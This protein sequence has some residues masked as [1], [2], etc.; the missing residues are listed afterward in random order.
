MNRIP[1]T[2]RFLIKAQRPNINN[3]CLMRSDETKSFRIESGRL[4]NIAV[5]Y[6][7]ITYWDATYA[8]YIRKG[9]VDIS[10]LYFSGNGLPSVYGTNELTAA[11][12]LLIRLLKAEDTHLEIPYITDAM[13]DKAYDI[14]TGMK[15]MPRPQGGNKADFNDLLR[16]LLTYA[17][18]VYRRTEKPFIDVNIQ[19]PWTILMEE[20]T[21]DFARAIRYRKNKDG[22][23]VPGIRSLIDTSHLALWEEDEQERLY[24][25]RLDDNRFRIGRSWQV[26]NADTRKVFM[27]YTDTLRNYYAKDD[28]KVT[29]S[30]YYIGVPKCRL[31]L[32]LLHG[33]SECHLNGDDEY[34]YSLPP[35]I[36]LKTSL[37]DALPYTDFRDDN[38]DYLSYQGRHSDDSEKKTGYILAVD[39]AMLDANRIEKDDDID[40]WKT[41]VVRNMIRPLYIGEDIS[42]SYMT[43]PSLAVFNLKAITVT[44]LAEIVVC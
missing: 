43:T 9:Y 12:R 34:F 27:R 37:D 23:V 35:S 4:G 31:A 25:W 42:Y 33:F 21:L 24:N 39:V 36:R 2:S 1:K 22:S 26:E 8:T 3:V 6:S 32:I 28:E 5:E 17:P 41:D 11:E 15:L 13:F 16:S 19:I 29:I 14:L 30:R 7:P 38:L 18:Q 44:G 10:D 40:R 20:A